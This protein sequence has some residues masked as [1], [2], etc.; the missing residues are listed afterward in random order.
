MFVLKGNLK[1]NKKIYEEGQKIE[2][3]EKVNRFAPHLITQKKR[4]ALLQLQFW[5]NSINL[6]KKCNFNYS[7]VVYLY[8]H[9]NKSLS[10]IQKVEGTLLSQLKE[11]YGSEMML[12]PLPGD[13]GLVSIDTIKS[14]YNITKL[15][16]IIVN[17]KYVFE[18]RTNKSQIEE[19][20]FKR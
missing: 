17:E 6:R 5:F 16:A 4:Y 12:I 9:Y 10:N 8:S 1:F 13:L 20:L 2:R 11:E 3:Y 14:Q 18:G 7:T 19:V 15:P